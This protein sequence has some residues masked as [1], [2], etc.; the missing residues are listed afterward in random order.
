MLLP[1]WFLFTNACYPL[2]K[3]TRWKSKTQLSLGIPQAVRN[4]CKY[5]RAIIKDKAD[6]YVYRDGLPVGHTGNSKDSIYPTPY[7]VK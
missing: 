4:M 5:P 6:G 7:D 1:A 2:D 3:L